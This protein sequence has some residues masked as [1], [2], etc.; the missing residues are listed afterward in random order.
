MA[1]L[2]SQVGVGPVWGHILLQVPICGPLSLKLTCLQKASSVQQLDAHLVLS[3]H[4]R[5]HVFICACVTQ[6]HLPFFLPR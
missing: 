3:K 5:A 1:C 2:R 4:S 6:R